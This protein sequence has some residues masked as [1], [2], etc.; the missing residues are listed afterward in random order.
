MTINPLSLIRP[1]RTATRT[2]LWLGA[3][4]V[5][6]ACGDSEPPRVVVEGG[7]QLK[8]AEGQ[9]FEAAVTVEPT[10][11]DRVTFAADV[12]A[13][14]QAFFAELA[15]V[16]GAAGLP[17]LRVTPNCDL[18]DAGG[19][20]TVPV[21]VRAV[22]GATAE[23][24]KLAVQ[25]EA[26]PD[27]SCLPQLIVWRDPG[28][29]C[30]VEGESLDRDV[31]ALTPGDTATICVVARSLDPS[32]ES[33]WLRTTTDAPTTLISSV[34]IASDVDELDESFDVLSN[35]HVVGEFAVDLAVYR[36]DPEDRDG[37]ETPTPAVQRT[38]TLQMGARGDVAIELI[39]D[40]VEP[41]NAPE[42][43]ATAVPFRLWQYGDIEGGACVWA[44]RLN[45]PGDAL[46]RTK[47]FLRVYDAEGDVK[48]PGEALCGPGPYTLRVSPP[49]DSSATEQVRLSVGPDVGTT[50]A[51]RDVQFAVVSLAEELSC[52][53]ISDTNPPPPLVA[54]ADLAFDSTPEVL[55][56]S[57]TNSRRAC[58]FRGTD[59]R[60][61]AT[62]LTWVGDNSAPDA[63][64]SFRW[65]NGSGP[66]DVVLGE[67]GSP[68]T[69]AQLTIDEAAQTVTWAPAPVDIALPA[70]L[71]LAH[72][73]PLA[74]QVA[75][76]A[77]HLVYAEA[78]A[79]Q[80]SI[81]VDCISTA[82]GC[83]SFSIDDLAP[84]SVIS[85]ARVGVADMNGDGDNDLIFFGT[86]E[87]GDGR[88]SLQIAVVQPD[89]SSASAT[90][91]TLAC[92]AFAPV[93][94]TAN[95]GEMATLGG[96]APQDL[97][98][99]T[100]DSDFDASL[101]HLSGASNYFT[102]PPAGVGGFLV[103]PGPAL[104]LA[105]S[106]GML[107]AG[108]SS[109]VWEYDDSGAIATWTLRDPVLQEDAAVGA[110][111]T[112]AT[113]YGRALAPCFRA[114]GLPRAVVFSSSNISVRYTEVDVVVVEP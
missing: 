11:R 103:T 19:S 99:V 81:S 51:N 105:V 26:Q 97:Y 110:I 12:D 36:T 13:S 55:I 70:G 101:L 63:I 43:D 18:V 6:A 72:V 17:V 28:D 32:V 91:A 86:I 65:N 109:G 54:C 64:L 94:I 111:P 24:A 80:W 34:P 92:V 77:T 22:S 3:L 30:A 31:V 112:T 113:G 50:V 100:G 78:R 106:G 52:E 107:I 68:S 96:G 61:V 53:D 42:F 29:G 46:P 58:V 98:A 87:Q 49:I 79:G 76:P 21:T 85:E 95:L 104:D 74:Q 83:T 15:V 71:P 5:V 88:R 23:P 60:F 73:R 27:G 89:W 48:D 41:I 7:P 14:A 1:T 66:Q 57:A 59:G 69:L 2:R 47:P 45:P 44:E 40:A 8:V 9:R 62:P 4:F 90:C 10:G 39:G 33:L 102:A 67:V 16:E 25:I 35:A 75:A 114:D 37:G 108:L 56:R 20:V 93:A 38:L 84:T 82:T